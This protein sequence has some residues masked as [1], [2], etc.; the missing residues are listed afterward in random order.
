MQVDFAFLCDA[1]TESGGKV[2]ALGIGF[3]RITVRTL[4]VVHP[5]AVAVVRFGF[6]RS[7]TGEHAFRVRVSDADGRDIAPPV[8]GQINLNV[9]DEVG[10][11]ANMIVD[12]VQLDLRTQGPH[13]VNV[14]LDGQEIVSLP[15]EVV[16]V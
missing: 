16:Q 12:L 1:A 15:F 7:D 6:N 5:R 10:G 2:H 3:E 14:T 8:E 9:G 11:K 4:P 13:E